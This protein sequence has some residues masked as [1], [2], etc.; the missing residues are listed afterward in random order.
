M[1][2]TTS[3][4]GSAKEK[5]SD[6]M[7]VELNT[8]IAAL[9][10]AREED[11]AKLE[12]FAKELAGLKETFL[13]YD[14]TVRFES[15]QF[16]KLLKAIRREDSGNRKIADEIEKLAVEVLKLKPKGLEEDAVNVTFKQQLKKALGRDGQAANSGSN[17]DES[18]LG[19]RAFNDR[20]QQ[21]K[22]L[23]DALGVRDKAANSG[24]NYSDT[25]Q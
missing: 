8:Q 19:Q 2:K 20:F 9:T 16:E 10:K 25:P 5:T 18:P 6:E 24:S 4:S 22:Q 1:A 15:E 13:P 7:L 23:A 11:K 12:V 21:Q 3:T 14:S 17:Y